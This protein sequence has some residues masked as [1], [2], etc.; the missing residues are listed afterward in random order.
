MIIIL[1]LSVCLSVC[2]SVACR[3]YAAARR[4]RGVVAMAS[5]VSTSAIELLNHHPMLQMLGFK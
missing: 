1:Y 5:V 3:S 2:L 4:L